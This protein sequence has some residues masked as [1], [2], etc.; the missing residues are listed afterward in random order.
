MDGDTRSDAAANAVNTARPLVSVLIPTRNSAL[1]LR[2]CIHS[3]RAQRDANLEVIVIDNG[4]SDDTLAIAQRLA[5]VVVR[6]GSER[7]SQLNAGARAAR[8]G[9]PSTRGAP[10]T[11]RCTTAAA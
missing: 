9:S 8:G 3:L 7:T 11:A 5:D 6:E 2:A 1:H 4:S 10:P